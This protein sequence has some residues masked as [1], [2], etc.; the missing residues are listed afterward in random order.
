M[1]LQTEVMEIVLPALLSVVTLVVGFVGHKVNVF[2]Q[3]K[4]D[5]TKQSVIDK[6]IREAVIF[7]EQ[8]SGVNIAMTSMEKLKL[9]KERALQ[10][11]ANKGLNVSP[12]YLDTLIEVFV[13]E[14]Q[15]NKH[16]GD[17]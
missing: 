9:A 15:W 8:V 2:V 3:S 16:K 10:N 6:N 5:I 12:E 4:I 1:D 7:V 13:N 11:L 17:N 14:L